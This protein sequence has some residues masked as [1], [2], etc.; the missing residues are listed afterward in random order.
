MSDL[1]YD[2]VEFFLIN[3]SRI[4]FIA[5]VT[6]DLVFRIK[7]GELVKF[8][9][10]QVG[11]KGGGKPDMAQAGGTDIAKLPQAMNGVAGWLEEH[12]G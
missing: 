1:E 10:A 7:A 8:V 6:R 9:A 2:A 11:G 5:G 12:L 4:S 3:D